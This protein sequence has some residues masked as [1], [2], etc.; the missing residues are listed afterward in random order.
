MQI[1]L[2]Q[3]EKIDSL[4]LQQLRADNFETCADPREYIRNSNR[5]LDACIDAMGLAYVDGF[6]SA[7]EC[8]AAIVAKALETTEE[9]REFNRRL[10]ARPMSP[11]L[12]ERIERINKVFGV[13]S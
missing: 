7:E 3:F 9:E 4:L 6:A 12:A 2:T 10:M 11:A 5:L 8:A 1:T 13:K